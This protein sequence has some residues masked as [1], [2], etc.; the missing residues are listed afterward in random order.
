M[1]STEQH[2]PAWYPDPLG[3]HEHRWYDGTQWTDHVSSHGRQGV[4]PVEKG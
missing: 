2:S 4:E 3:Q 1:A